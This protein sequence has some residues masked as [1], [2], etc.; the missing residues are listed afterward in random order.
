MS[1]TERSE[2]AQILED[3]AE[4]L[5]EQAAGLRTAEP[6]G[7]DSDPRAT[8]HGVQEAILKALRDASRE[9]DDGNNR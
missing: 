8:L 6:G 9:L 2:L 7:R 1:S 3:I 4:K 5:R